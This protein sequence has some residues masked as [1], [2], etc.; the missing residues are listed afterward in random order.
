MS[1]KILAQEYPPA[2]EA[3]AISDLAQRL[4]DKI[5]KQYANDIMRRDAHPKMHGLVRAEFT[6]EAG[7]PEQWR[8]GVFREPKTY[9]AWIRFSNQN[10]EIQS[11]LKNDIRGMAIKLL[12]V[13]G[14][15]LLESERHAT[16]HDFIVISTNVFV[17]KDAAEFDALIKAMLGGL[18]ATG[19]F[20]LT[21][22]RVTWNLMRSMK[23][24]GNPLRSRYWST[25][26]YLFGTQA[27][28]YSA[29]PVVPANCTDDG[30]PANPGDNYLREAM[31]DVLAREDVYFDFAVQKQ[32]DA[33]TMP[34]EDPG[35]E[36]SEQISPFV[37]LASIRI[38][39]QEFDSTA[40]RNF[41]ENLSYNPWHSLPEHR[42]LGG[43]NRARKIVYE[44]I[45]N[46]RHLR[47]QV[48]SV[49]PVS[50]DIP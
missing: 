37:K 2:G 20:F 45:S 3:Q 25:T 32:I 26:P 15:K 36:W 48:P 50:L 14:E 12:G 43:I 11:D 44:T 49:E 17:T 34:I 5:T 13:P 27:V 4:Q 41:G 46:F 9:Q 31:V 40:Q 29:I 22:L 1:Q 8:L 47:N 6:V 42:P 24:C 10:A 19:W 21:H 39:K 28:K 23:K 38:P 33:D 18:L 16:T 7:I 30:I 35:V